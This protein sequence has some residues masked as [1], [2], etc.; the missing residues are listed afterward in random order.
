M[1]RQSKADIL[2]N[3]S[4][5]PYLG[6]CK[7]YWIFGASGVGKS[8]Y[9]RSINSGSYV[10]PKSTG[11]NGYEQEQNVLFDDFEL[12]CAKDM[13]PDLKKWSNYYGK[14]KDKIKREFIEL[15][16][17]RLYIISA[18]FLKQFFEDFSQIQVNRVLGFT[19]SIAKYFF[20]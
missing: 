11:W 14:I 6:P 13:L 17:R 10:K 18:Y 12:M 1:F 16:Y 5:N 9:V 4:I 2:K 19:R 15:K 8:Y 7:A 20:H 3:K